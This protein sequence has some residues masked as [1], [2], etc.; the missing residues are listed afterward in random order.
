MVPALSGERVELRVMTEDHAAA[1]YDLWCHPEVAPWL[2]MPPLSS[3]ADAEHLIGL[4]RQMAREEESLRWS[5]IGPEGDVIGS[6]GYNYWQLP[7]A[8]RGEIGCELSPSHWGQGYM[9]EALELVLDFGFGTMGLNRIEVLC[10][11]DNVRAQRLFS[12]L[13]FRKEGLLREYRHT[14]SGFQDVILYA[15]LRSEARR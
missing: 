9:Q 14:S 8:Y 15:L 5:I 7:G 13:G 3:A 6:C 1:L 12:A 10:H 2:D 4:L 11:P